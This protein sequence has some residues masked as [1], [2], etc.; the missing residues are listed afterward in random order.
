MFDNQRDTESTVEEFTSRLIINTRQTRL[1][2]KN[3]LMSSATDLDV[4]EFPT[5]LLSVNFTVNY[6]IN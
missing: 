4:T 5:S 6:C 3:Y 1:I 2:D